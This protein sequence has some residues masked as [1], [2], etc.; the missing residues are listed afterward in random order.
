MHLSVRHLSN[1]LPHSLARK[2]PLATFATGGART[3]IYGR[4]VTLFIKAEFD[5]ESRL[6]IYDWKAGETTMVSPTL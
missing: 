3:R 6:S 4:Y 2:T 1:G 5:L